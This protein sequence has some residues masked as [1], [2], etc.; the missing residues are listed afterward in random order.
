MR[1]APLVL[2]SWHWEK[3]RKG[4]DVTLLYLSTS[5]LF[6]FDDSFFD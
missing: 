4:A 5:F 1:N 2:G 6:L 3:A